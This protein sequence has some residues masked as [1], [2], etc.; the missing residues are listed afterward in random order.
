MNLKRLRLFQLKEAKYQTAIW[1]KVLSFLMPTETSKSCQWESAEI[2]GP[3]CHLRRKYRLSLHILINQECTA[4]C[5]ADNFP[6]D[7]QKR[8]VE[9]SRLNLIGSNDVRH[10]DDT[11]A[12]GSQCRVTQPRDVL[13]QLSTSNIRLEYLE[14][15]MVYLSSFEYG[16]HLLKK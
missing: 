7:F 15:R 2:K 13:D 5:K 1:P 11:L 6:Q 3:Q 14:R 9:I 8:A 16:F 4:I 10:T 12:G